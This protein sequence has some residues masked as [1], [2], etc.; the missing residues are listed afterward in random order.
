MRTNLFRGFVLG[1]LN[2]YADDS[3]GEMR[4]WAQTKDKQGKQQPQAPAEQTPGGFSISVTVPV[5]SVEVV[6][7]DNNGI[8]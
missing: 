4:A 3:G 6:L 8:F 1:T 2:F 5:V 7:T